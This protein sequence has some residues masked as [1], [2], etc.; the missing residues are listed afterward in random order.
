MKKWDLIIIIVLTILSLMP[1]RLLI[2]SNNSGDL[3]RVI[4]SVNGE[5]YESLEL[6]ENVNEIIKIEEGLG[7]NEICIKKG[8]V[9]MNHSN[10]TDKV[11]M[12]QGKISKVGESIVCLPNRVFIEIKGEKESECILSY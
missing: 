9:Y 5:E 3:K 12:R 2:S 6:K 7:V 8:Q 1:I 4:I 11:C 10:C